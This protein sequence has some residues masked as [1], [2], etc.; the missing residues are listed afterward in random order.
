MRNT[1]CGNFFAN[2]VDTQKVGTLGQLKKLIV[3]EKKK[4]MLPI[5]AKNFISIKEIGGSMLPYEVTPK[6]NSFNLILMRILLER[7]RHI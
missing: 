1:K 5:A 3:T 2:I 4:G 7:L 6:W